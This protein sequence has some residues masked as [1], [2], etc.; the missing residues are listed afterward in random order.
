[1]GSGGEVQVEE[2]CVYSWLTHV[3]WKKT[4]QYGKTII[5]QLKIN[6]I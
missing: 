1:M 5:L 2:T 3:V 6:S 4:T